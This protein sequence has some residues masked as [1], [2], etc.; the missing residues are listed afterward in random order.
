ML[1]NQIDNN[2]NLSIFEKSKNFFLDWLLFFSP[3][4][5]PRSKLNS[6]IGYQTLRIIVFSIPTLIFRFFNQK[7]IKGFSKNDKFYISKNSEYFTSQLRLDD[8]LISSLINILNHRPIN[9]YYWSK[10]HSSGGIERELN[11]EKE[12]KFEHIK[13]NREIIGDLNSLFSNI[14]FK[15]LIKVSSYIAGYPLKESRY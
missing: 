4:K 2:I 12:F 1:W 9:Q 13:L 14:G 7:I 5:G 10:V 11:H 3:C 6:Q 15:N 8:E